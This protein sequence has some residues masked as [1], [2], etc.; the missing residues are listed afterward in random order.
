MS[1][2]DGIVWYTPFPYMLAGLTIGAVI[3]FLWYWRFRRG[4]K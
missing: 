2:F 1:A 4:D 3:F